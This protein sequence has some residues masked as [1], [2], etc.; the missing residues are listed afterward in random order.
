MKHR[1]PTR[2]QRSGPRLSAFLAKF[3]LGH[4][5][6]LRDTIGEGD[7]QITRPQLDFSLL[8]LGLRK[9]SDDGAARLTASPP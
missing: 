5:A 4:V 2:L 9:Q 8:I 6:R 7:E 3:L 1:P